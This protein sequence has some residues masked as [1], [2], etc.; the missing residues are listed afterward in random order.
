MLAEKVHAFRSGF[1]ACRV[2]TTHNWLIWEVLFQLQALTH[3][4]LS[5]VRSSE[6][7]DVFFQLPAERSLPNLQTLTLLECIASVVPL[8]NCAPLLNLQDFRLESYALDMPTVLGMQSLAGV[9]C[10]SLKASKQVEVI[11]DLHVLLN[12]PLMR[13]K[14][15][16]HVIVTRCSFTTRNVPFSYCVEPTTCQPVL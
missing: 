10:L 6:V 5:V 2:G 4:R 11:P 1:P 15:P 16:S 14:H 8:T 7:E 12:S 3:L 9:K 13:W